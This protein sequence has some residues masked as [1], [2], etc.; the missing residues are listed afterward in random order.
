[1]AV[2]K[3]TKPAA[4]DNCLLF[5]CDT[6]QDC[7]L[8]MAVDGINTYDIFKGNMGLLSLFLHEFIIS[9]PFFFC[10]CLLYF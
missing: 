7:P 4:S 2:F 8:M 1:M 9:S 10:G 5:H 3:S 6:E